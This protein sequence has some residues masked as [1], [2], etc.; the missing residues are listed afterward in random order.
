MHRVVENVS[1]FCVFLIQRVWL[2]GGDGN[3][4]S[5]L[6]PI[7]NMES[8]LRLFFQSPPSLSVPSKVA[9]L[10]S[11][12]TASQSSS[13]ESNQ[14]F[15]ESK[16]ISTSNQKVLLNAL[17]SLKAESSVEWWVRAGV[18][19]IALGSR[20]EGLIGVSICYAFLVGEIKFPF[21]T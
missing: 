11:T 18:V 5:T 1:M 15:T 3:A 7:T 20:V 2:A 21:L 9:T 8:F 12:F 14:R 10:N 16:F 6:L 19:P 17:L 4:P 13:T